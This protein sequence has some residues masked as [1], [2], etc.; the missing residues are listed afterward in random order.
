MNFDV[1]ARAAKETGVLLEV[2]NHSYVST[3][4]RAGSREQAKIMLAACKKYGTAVIMGSDAHIDF[5][6]GNH[7][8]SI[9]VIKE[10]NFPE[11]LVINSDPAHF[12]EIVKY[13]KSLAPK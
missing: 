5:D 13:R 6:V 3:G 4:H 1:V 12:L 8:N 2:N 9:E 10:N 11:E 7:K